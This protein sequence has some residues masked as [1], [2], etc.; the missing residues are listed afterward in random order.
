MYEVHANII[1]Q[2]KMFI[3]M[4]LARSW[5]MLRHRVAE[6]R[7]NVHISFW[8]NCHN[9]QLQAQQSNHVEKY[10]TPKEI[11]LHIFISLHSFFFLT[12]A[13]KTHK[14]IMAR[15]TAWCCCWMHFYSFTIVCCCCFSWSCVIFTARCM[16]KLDARRSWFHVPMQSVRMCVLRMCV[17]G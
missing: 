15:W 14:M 5:G 8:I 1:A 13:H 11:C 12:C 4:Q 10:K 9:Y 2:H 7:L 17:G 16:K 3:Q 6:H